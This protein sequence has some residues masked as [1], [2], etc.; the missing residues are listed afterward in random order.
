MCFMTGTGRGNGLNAII[1]RDGGHEGPKHSMVVYITLKGSSTQAYA[2]HSAK[3]I[4]RNNYRIKSIL[5][6]HYNGYKLCKN[7]IF[8]NECS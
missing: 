3:P 1:L 2:L 8:T 4:S 5:H 6:G 7:C